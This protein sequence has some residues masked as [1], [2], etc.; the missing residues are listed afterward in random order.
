MNSTKRLFTLQFALAVAAIAF[1]LAVCAQAQTFT[2]VAGFNG[3]NGENPFYGSLIQAPNGNYYGT[4]H[5]GG[6]NSSGVVFEVTPAGKLS[7]IYSFCSQTNC[8]DGTDPW[9]ALVLGSNGDFY[10]TTN[11]GGANNSGTVFKMT[12][13][14]KLTTLYSFCPVTGCTD[15]QY[16]VGLTQASNGNFYGTTS[17]G[18]SGNDGTIFEVSSAGTFKLLYS[19]CSR[20]SCADGAEPL[21]G[22][23][24]A[25]NGNLYGTTNSGG[26]H[27]AGMVYEITTAGLFKVVY[28]F[29]SQTD[30]ADG[31]LHTRV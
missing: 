9:S 11:I 24:Q 30:C 5:D 2:S 19:F 18:G 26:S 29:C 8:A 13:G 12:V 4:T 16:P 17:N 3:T 23:M 31:K 25:S 1:S 15:G 22:P 6:K 21:S 7:D 27:D 20:K 28:N 14:G 10:G